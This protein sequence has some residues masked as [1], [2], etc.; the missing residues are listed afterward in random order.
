MLHHTRYNHPGY[1]AQSIHAVHKLL[2]SEGSA[3]WMPDPCKNLVKT[4]A[5]PSYTLP[6][7]FAPISENVIFY[8][9]RK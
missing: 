1:W 7:V 5:D 8:W 6:A 2:T 4:L 3:E 9:T